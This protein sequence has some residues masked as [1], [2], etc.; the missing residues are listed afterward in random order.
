[1][2]LVTEKSRAAFDLTE[3]ER[4]HLLWGRHHIWNEGRAGFVTSATEDR[5]IVQYYPGIGNVTNHFIIP[6]TEA[7]DGQWEIR[8]SADMA[9][10]KEYGIVADGEQQEAEGAKD[11]DTGGI[12]S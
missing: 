9:E 2:A 12:D 6:V 3:I 10:I 5:L 1:M 7:V 8:W 11:N 4:G